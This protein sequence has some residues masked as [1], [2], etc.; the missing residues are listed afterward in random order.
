M[1][2]FGVL[3][4]NRGRK[5]TRKLTGRGELTE[6]VACRRKTA[7]VVKKTRTQRTAGGLQGLSL[8]VGGVV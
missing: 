4:H 8:L 6:V 7:V 2:V 3:S 1:A 5:E